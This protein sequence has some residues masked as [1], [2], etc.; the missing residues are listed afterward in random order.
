[1]ITNPYKILGVPDGASEEECS[2][3]YRKLAKKYHPDLNPDDEEA[4]RK[5][6]EINAAFDQIKNGSAN[7]SAYSYSSRSAD[8]SSGTNYYSSAEQFI[9]NGQYSQ[10]LN[11]L[12]QIEDRNAQWYYLS[13][14]ANVG[15]GNRSVALSHIQQACAMEPNNFTYN[16]TYTKIRNSGRPSYSYRSS[17]F[18][19]YSD[20]EDSNKR[21]YYH[22]ET[23]SYPT[24]KRKN[25]SCLGRIIRFIIIW[26][27]LETV[28]SAVNLLLN[29][30]YPHERANSNYSYSKHADED[31]YIPND[32]ADFEHF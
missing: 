2:K 7:S 13:S 25:R 8:S 22:T 11:V 24:G 19:D 28:F 32:F 21:H 9:R 20:F 18:E 3:A 6:A 30:N 1:M 4:A 10:A 12:N 23:Y 15:L 14:L 26:I 31:E 5:M 27:I 16:L 17:P 29:P